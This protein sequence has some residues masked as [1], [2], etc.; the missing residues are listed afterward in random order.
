[1]P[2]IQAPEAAIPVAPVVAAPALRIGGARLQTSASAARVAAAA[3][4]PPAPPMHSH[5]AHEPPVSTGPAYCKFHSKVLAR[6]LCNQCHKSF[7]DLCVMTRNVGAAVHKT[8]RTCGVECVP[9][10]VKIQRPS[11]QK[12]FFSRLPG[13]IVYPFRGS[14]V[15]VLIV[16]TLLFA[17]LDFISA[18]WLGIFVKIIALGYLYSYMQNIIHSTAAGDEELSDLPGMDDVFSG[19]FRLVG[20]ALVCFGPAIVLAYFAIA[21][22]QPAAGIAMIP[23]I[24]F[25]CVYFPMAFLAVAM[26]DSVMAAN[27]LVVIPS[28]FKAPLEYLV[29]VVLLAVVFGT[30]FTGDFVVALL[31]SQTYATRSMAELFMTFGVRAFWAFASVYLLTVNMRILGL[32]YVTKKEKLGWF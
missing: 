14:G 3:E 28:I 31:S 16:A 11:G 25:G 21:H 1:L 23:A 29:T 26:K 15:L 4:P 12:G 7:C 20:T 17:A 18:G 6:W 5:A 10:Q 9:V 30:R 13:A 24:I 32:L 8:C 27:P 22:E 19:C 2:R